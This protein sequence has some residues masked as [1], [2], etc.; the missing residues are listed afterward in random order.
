MKVDKGSLKSVL[1]NVEEVEKSNFDFAVGIQVDKDNVL[2][3]L[4]VEGLGT[5]PVPVSIKVLT[6]LLIYCSNLILIFSY[7]GFEPIK[8]IIR[9]RKSTNFKR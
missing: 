6:S 8:E 4:S 9:Y 5:I 3:M 2:P 7:T 1:Q